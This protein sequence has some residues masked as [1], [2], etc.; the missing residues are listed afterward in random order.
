M[1]IQNVR[2]ISVTVTIDGRENDIFTKL[3][4]S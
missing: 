3:K 2:I 1:Q 4:E